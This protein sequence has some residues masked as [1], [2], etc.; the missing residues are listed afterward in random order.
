MKGARNSLLHFVDKHAV[1]QCEN[2][3]KCKKCTCCVGP[4]CYRHF[5]IGSA[6]RSYEAVLV[7]I[8]SSCRNFIV[9]VRSSWRGKAQMM[10][11]LLSY[12][13]C[14]HFINEIKSEK[15]REH[16]TQMMH[17][18][19]I[20]SSCRHFINEVKSEKFQEYKT[21]MMHLLCW[22]ILP[23]DIPSMRSRVR[24]SRT[25]KHRFCIYGVDLFFLQTFHQWDQECEVPGP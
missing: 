19:L 8:C 10:H 12:S 13:P 18:F 17:L 20:Y 14:R 9:R 16:K 23:A 4:F 25:I 11:L 6:V 15:F 24:R 7:L 1:G 3:R 22:F 5:I 21:Q 2:F